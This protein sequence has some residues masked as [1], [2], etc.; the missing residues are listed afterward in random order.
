MLDHLDAYDNIGGSWV[1]LQALLGSQNIVPFDGGYI[2]Q[3]AVA[4]PEPSTLAL[5]AA[6]VALTLYIRRKRR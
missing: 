2:A 5:L 4:V 1:S 6:A 3:Q